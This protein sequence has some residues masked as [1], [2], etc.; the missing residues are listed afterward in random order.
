MLE[1]TEPC[2]QW[3]GGYYYVGEDSPGLA[4]GLGNDNAVEQGQA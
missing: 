3:A 2:Q 4:Q 1:V